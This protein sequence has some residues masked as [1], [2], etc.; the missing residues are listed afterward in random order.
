MKSYI[1]VVLMRVENKIIQNL[2]FNEEYCR[3]AAPHIKLEYFKERIDKS[4]V[5]VIL[6]FFLKYNKVPTPDVVKLELDKE[7]I[8]DK[9]L[10]TAYEL[11]DSLKSDST[12]IEYNIEMT[13]KFCQ[14]SALYNAILK[15]IAII[16]GK[17]KEF[18]QEALPGILQDA[19]SVSFDTNIGHDYVEDADARYDFYKRVEEKVPFDIDILN[20]I[21][22]GGLSN[23]SLNIVLAPTGAGKTL[24]KCHIAAATL[25]QNKNVLYITNEMAE[26]RIAERIDANLMN[27]TLDELKVID[28]EAYNSRFNKIKGK[29][30]GRLIIKEYPTATAHSGHFR[31]LLEELRI[32]KNFIPKLIIIDYLNICASAR[33][34]MGASINSYTYIKSIAEELRGLAVEYNVPILSST[35]TNRD[36]YANSDVD[37]SNVSESA[38]LSSTADLVI[39]II[40]TEELDELNQL[41]VKQ[42]KNRYSDLAKNKRFVLGVD[43]SKMKLYE[44]EDS[45]QTLADSGTQED[46]GTHWKGNTKT[47]A[48]F[49]DFKY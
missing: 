36:G 26:E 33:M 31:A 1:Q 30:T 17:D 40:R 49:G 32:K 47:R 41:V 46:S 14:D 23:K 43:R 44:V 27:L 20:E 7:K 10:S 38:G 25:K 21:T 3:K 16:D 4:I 22:S 11:V 2:L 28:R 35:Q 39:A 45:A 34:R 19:L 48:S 37:L 24:V 6:E 18:T 15:S 5:K 8:S 29:T 12:P 9:E 42:L 13:E